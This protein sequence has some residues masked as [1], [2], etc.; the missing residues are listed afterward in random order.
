MKKFLIACSAAALMSAP[1]A[2]AQDEADAPAVAAENY[3]EDHPWVGL[4]VHDANDER[5]G[6]V[7]KVMFADGVQTRDGDETDLAEA[8]VE[9]SAFI[10]ETGGFLGVGDR[11]VQVDTSEAELLE[12]DDHG[13]HIVLALSQDEVEALPTTETEGDEGDWDMEP[14]RNEDPAQDDADPYGDEPMDDSMA[15]EAAMDDEAAAADMSAESEQHAWVGL[16]VHAGVDDERV[17]SVSD[18]RLNASGEVEA[19]IIETGGF[20]GIGDREVEID[21]SEFEPV[22]VDGEERVELEMSEDELEA[23]PEHDDEGEAY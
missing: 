6:S 5:I 17:G 19:I 16:P 20:L 15:D 11:E 8:D 22:S 18:V 14:D 23:L 12:D 21:S 10:I 7:Q 9:I 3:T 2:M 4:P 13:E 1:A